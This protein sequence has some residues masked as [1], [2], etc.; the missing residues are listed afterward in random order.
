MKKAWQLIAFV[1]MV[2]LSSLIVLPGTAAGAE[3]TVCRHQDDGEAVDFRQVEPDQ[4]TRAQQQLGF[5][6][7]LQSVSQQY[8]IAMPGCG[9]YSGKS[10]TTGSEDVICTWKQCGGQD[11]W[12]VCSCYGSPATWHCSSF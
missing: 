6:P 12:N 1:T 3:F 8:C 10:C 4:P 11:Y 5:N 9:S 2:V 7:S